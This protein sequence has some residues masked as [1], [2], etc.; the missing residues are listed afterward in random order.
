MSGGVTPE[1]LRRIEELYH[2]ARQRESVE[3]EAFL[4]AACSGDAELLYEV[5]SLLAQDSS[6][7]LAQPVLEVAAN[8]FG[9]VKP[10]TRLGPYEIVS[11]LGEGGMGA[12]YKAQDTRLVRAV[13]IKFV[14]EGFSSRFQREARTISALNHPHICTLH[15]VGPN[16]LVMELVEGETLAARLDKGPLPTERV[17]RYGAEIADGL[18]AAHARGIIHRDLK[19]ANIMLTRNGVKVLDFGLAKFTQLDSSAKESQK[20][21]GDQV[22]LGTPAYMAPEQLAG[23][24]C[25]ERSDIYSFGLVLHEM[26]AGKRAPQERN[27]ASRGPEAESYPGVAPLD[28]VIRKCLAQDPEERWQSARDLKTNLDWAD[29]WPGVEKQTKTRP[30]KLVWGMAAV[31]LAIAAVIGWFMWPR[32]DLP[33]A[34]FMLRPPEGTRI[35]LRLP[36]KPLATVSLD[37]ENVVLVAQD[38]AGVRSLWLRPLSSTAYRRLDRTEGASL[39]FW[40]PNSQ[41]IAFFADGKLKKVSVSGGPS[42]TICEVGVG[43]GEGGT[44]NQDGVILFPAPRKTANTLPTGPLYRVPSAGGRRATS[45]HARHGSRR[46]FSFVAA[47]LAGWSPLYILGSK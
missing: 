16:Y 11:L 6:G 37:G 31:A 42:Q 14:H 2:L 20:I 15:D 34:H 38:D 17:A 44:W 9:G 19:P 43:D 12:V 10:G 46:G 35:A 33:R 3:R 39:A 21:T 1:R 26:L 22:I 28:R 7:P 5:A 36:N 8:L 45:N 18:A 13:A 30:S 23:Q 40:S 41:F 25:D 47:I 29:R 4:A 32:S 24:E 27:T